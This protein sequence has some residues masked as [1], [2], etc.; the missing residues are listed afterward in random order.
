MSSPK[1]PSSSGHE[2]AA[3][4]AGCTRA[5][6]FVVVSFL[7]TSCLGL[8]P[9]PVIT[10]HTLVAFGERDEFVSADD[11]VDVLE[12][13][14]ARAAVDFMQNCVGGRFAVRQ[15][16]LACGGETVGFVNL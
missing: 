5:L 14:V 8:Q 7:E 16:D 3:G 6:H 1:A 4:D 9:F 15:H 12:R 11:V 10:R 2:Y 13:L